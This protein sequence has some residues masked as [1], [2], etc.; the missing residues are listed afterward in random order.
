MEVANKRGRGKEG[1]KQTIFDMPYWTIW[2][3]Q[4]SHVSGLAL[5]NWS[6]L[7]EQGPDFD[8]SG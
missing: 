1:S 8:Y 5:Q 2:V 7:G 6:H 4:H 3:K